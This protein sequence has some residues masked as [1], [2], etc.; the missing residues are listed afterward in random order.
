ME[1]NVTLISQKNQFR[2]EKI[3]FMG[4]LLSKYGIGLTEE[5]ARA[6][7]E[8]N[9]PTKPTE[10]R[11]FLGIVLSASFVPMLQQLLQSL[12]ER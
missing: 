4:L 12:F 9:R 3:V 7:L 10:V 5:K 6:V 8:T 11:S 1:E 2:T